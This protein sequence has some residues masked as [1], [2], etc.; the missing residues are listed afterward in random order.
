MADDRTTG[1]PPG[2]EP[3]LRGPLAGVH[4]LL[5]PTLHSFAQVREDIA[6]WT[7]PLTDDEIWLRPCGLAPAGFQLRHIA[8]S[9]DRLTTYLEGRQLTVHQ[10]DELRHES[11]PGPGRLALLDAVN[12][13]LDESERVIRNLDPNTLTYPRTVGRKKLPTTV[14]GLI[15]HLAEHTQRHVGELI[16]TVKA[17][18]K[19]ASGSTST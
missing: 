19:C 13:A 14:I 8:G 11:D 18:Q 3:W 15:V 10:F 17:V 12:H 1:S 2:V 9:V 7:T 5:A 4:P 6:R 16:V